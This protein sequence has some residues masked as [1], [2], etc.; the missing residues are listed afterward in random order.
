[1]N[2]PHCNHNFLYFGIPLSSGDGANALDYFN[3][4]QG[5]TMSVRK[6][7]QSVLKL[8]LG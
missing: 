5:R 2:L 3:R 8:Q 4:F 7:E 6:L 1:M